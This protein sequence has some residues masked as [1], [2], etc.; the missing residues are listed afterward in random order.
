MRLPD[1]S[2]G[3]PRR[4]GPTLP[5]ACLLIMV[6]LSSCLK[7]EEA[8]PIDNDPQAVVEAYLLPGS[9]IVVRVKREVPFQEVDDGSGLGGLFITVGHGTSVDTLFDEGN[10]IYS[11]ATMVAQSEQYAL[12]FDFNERR[13][14]SVTDIPISP[15]GFGISA[16]YLE[17]PVLEPGNGPPSGGFSFPDPIEVTWQNPGTAY[18]LV[19][20]ECIEDDPQQIADSDAPVRPRF[21]TEPTTNT[22]AELSFRDFTYFGTHRII[23]YRLNA[24]YAALYLDNGA[25]SQN[26]TTPQTNIVNGLGIFT[27]VNTDTLFLEVQEQ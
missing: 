2:Y 25:N 7:E 26:L 18:H 4:M 3:T 11:G 10:G 22:E 16:S 20:V 21:R 27:G 13:V 12:Q 23:L 9:P 8:T 15:V 5:V 24:D 17:I 1:R 14:T 19:V 6:A